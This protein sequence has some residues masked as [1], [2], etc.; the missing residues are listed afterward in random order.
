MRRLRGTRVLVVGD[1]MLDE[2][3]W[4]EVRRVSPEAPVTVVEMRRRTWVPGGAANAAANVV[5][6]GGRAWLA[7][8]VGRDPQAGWLTAVLGQHG[9]DVSGLVVDGRRPT[10]LKTRIVAHSQQVVRVDTETR[11]PLPAAVE[12]RLLAWVERRLPR[13][14]ACVL[15]DYGKG[16]VSRRVAERLI[17]VARRAGTPV[18]V[19]PKGTDYTK[20][21]GATLVTP[22]LA[23]AE[24]AVNREIAGERDVLAVGRRLLEMLDG[25]AVLITRGAQGMSLFR[26]GAAVVHIP[27]VARHVFDVTGAGDTV[28]GVLALALGAGV[29][30][31]DGARLANLAADLVVGKFGTATVSARE[32]VGPRGDGARR[33]RPAGHRA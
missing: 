9:V 8:V 7:A 24:R 3:V 31:D 20:Y 14:D 11:A 30:L 32:L 19:D 26:R 10:T 1:A 33:R 15:S 25:S 5:S 18:V 12:R 2:Y 4:G 28:V 22:N 27:A 23:E 21:R 29:S 17:A 16:V 13:A 6:L